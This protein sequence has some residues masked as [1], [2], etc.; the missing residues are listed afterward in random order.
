MSSES[1]RAGL[2]ELPVFQS[3][4]EESRSRIAQVFYD[5]SEDIG[6]DEGD[7]I[8]H[9]GYLSFDTGYVLY[10]GEAIVEPSNGDP[11]DVSAPIMVGE[12]SQ[13]SAGDTRTATVRA[14]EGVRA[15][16]FSWDDL[17]QEAEQQLSDEDYDALRKSVEMLVWKRFPY[18]QIT[19]LGLFADL[20]DPLKDRVCSPLPGITEAMRLETGD[21]LFREDTLCKA[22]GYLLLN[23]KMKLIR[24]GKG[25][26]P[27]EGLDIIGV[28]PS[29]S[30]KQ[31]K[32]SATCVA[33]GDVELLCFSWDKYTSL[34]GR[35]LSKE[36]RKQLVESMKNNA[37]MHFWH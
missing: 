6:Y 35:R 27:V 4:P 1:A 11:V 16:G 31:Y 2:V 22:M 29:K 7:V 21:T 18:R 9:E 33:A 28:F 34:L 14:K 36:E 10:E 19:E 24:A 23:G 12:M 32:W 30:D 20:P 3:I 17:Y 13:F 37:K 8:I 15:L 25:E 5:V 26:K